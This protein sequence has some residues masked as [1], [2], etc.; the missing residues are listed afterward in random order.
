MVVIDRQ[1]SEIFLN[2]GAARQLL[3]EGGVNFVLCV[4]LAFSVVGA[5]ALLGYCEKLP[6]KW[7]EFVQAAICGDLGRIFED[8]GELSRAP[9]ATLLPFNPV[10]VADSKTGRRFFACRHYASESSLWEEFVIRPSSKRSRAP[11]PILLRLLVFPGASRGIV[12]GG[13]TTGRI[14]AGAGARAPVL[15]SRGRWAG[16]RRA[17]EN[18]TALPRVRQISAHG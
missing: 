5:V 12:A 9:D 8:I 1:H 2:A 16:I 14:A 6:K 10:P 15:A 3:L 13:A 18:V 7:R 11:A 4:H 17:G